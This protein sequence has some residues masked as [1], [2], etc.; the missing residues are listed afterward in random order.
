[1]EPQLPDNTKEVIIDP[2]KAASF[3]LQHPERV[4]ITGKC[5]AGKTELGIE[6]ISTVFRHQ[7]DRLIVVC[8]TFHSQESFRRLDSMISREQDIFTHPTSK[9][10]EQ[11]QENIELVS[12]KLKAM[13]QRSL[14]TMVF[15]D[16]LSGLNII[17][18]GRLGAFANFS[19]KS[20][21]FDC[22][23]IVISQQATSVSPAFRDNVTAV[24]A[25]PSQRK[26]E[27]KWLLREYTRHDF[28][29]DHMKSLVTAAWRGK[30]KLEDE[31]GLHFFFV[32]CQARKPIRYFAD[33]EYQLNSSL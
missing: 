10:F 9:T 26:E 6:L 20:R 23:M 13:K 28:S 27:I 30:D 32:L 17:H 8:P 25:F 31:W 16:D 1:M 4:F 5:G 29:D 15:V 33:F 11:I 21:H 18:G 19:I 2:T 3:F 12:K 14:R 7:I 24:V 22:S